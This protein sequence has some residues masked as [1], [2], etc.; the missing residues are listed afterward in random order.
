MTNLICNSDVTSFYI[1]LF[2]IV[3]LALSIYYGIKYL[4][5]NYL[6]D[7]TFSSADVIFAPTLLE[8]LEVM[9]KDGVVRLYAT[10]IKD[11]LFVISTSIIGEDYKNGNLISYFGEKA[12][13]I[14]A[15]T[16]KISVFADRVPS[17]DVKGIVTQKVGEKVRI[18]NKGGN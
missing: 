1:P 8:D 15:K 11:N 7:K 9:K 13:V 5:C 17:L 6:N 4:I 3:V 18:K 2:I 10:K 14:E 16:E 12:T